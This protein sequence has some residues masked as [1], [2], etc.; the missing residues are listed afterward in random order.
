MYGRTAPAD[1]VFGEK[2]MSDVWQNFPCRPGVWREVDE[3]CMAE[4]HKDLVP[5]SSPHKAAARVWSVVGLVW[6]PHTRRFVPTCT[7]GAATHL[8]LMNLRAKSEKLCA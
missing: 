3:R 5:T 1:L 6:A 2:L 7:Q 8:S 4:L